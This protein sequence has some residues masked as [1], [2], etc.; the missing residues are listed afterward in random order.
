MKRNLTPRKDE[1]L[2]EFMQVQRFRHPGTLVGSAD[3]VIIVII[4][5]SI[6]CLL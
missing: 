5:L 4:M 3:F 6:E 2:R 1:M